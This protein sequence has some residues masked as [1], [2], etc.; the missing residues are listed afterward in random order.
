MDNKKRICHYNTAENNI[1]KKTN[2]ISKIEVTKMQVLPRSTNKNPSAGAI[3][4]L[5][6]RNN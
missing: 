5:T 3:K 1:S 4:E 2:K 6:I